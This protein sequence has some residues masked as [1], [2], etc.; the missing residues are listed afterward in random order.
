MGGTT[1]QLARQ[2]RSLQVDVG[3]RDRVSLSPWTHGRPSPSAAW[4][5]DSGLPIQPNSELA[6]LADQRYRV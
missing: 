6:L 2:V 5:E 3:Y 4:S 1:T